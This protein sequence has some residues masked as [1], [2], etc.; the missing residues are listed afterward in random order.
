MTD[1]RRC[2]RRQPALGDALGHARLR[3]GL[4]LEVTEIADGGARVRT[5]N[6]L[7][8]GTHV[9]VHFMTRGGRVLQRARIARAWVIQLGPSIVFEV[10]LHFD[11]TIDTRPWEPATRHDAADDL[12]NGAWI[13]RSSTPHASNAPDG[14]EMSAGPLALELETVVRDR[15]KGALW[16]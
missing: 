7:L 10:A 1:R 12:A 11:H 2:P 13:P 8:P 14:A 5:R 4:D 6:R 3:T 15:P 9:D 16:R